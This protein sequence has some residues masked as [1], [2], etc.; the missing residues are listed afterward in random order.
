MNQL[1]R[2]DIAQHRL[3]ALGGQTGDARRLIGTVVDQ[4]DSDLLAGE[5][6]I[7]EAAHADEAEHSHSWKEYA[8]WALGGIA[9]LAVLLTVGRRVMRSRQVR[10]GGA[11]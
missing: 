4:A 6:D 9:A 7:H 8:G 1:G 10:M 2:I 5:L 11:A 3:D